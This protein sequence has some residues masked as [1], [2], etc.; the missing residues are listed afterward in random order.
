VSSFWFGVLGGVAAEFLGL[1]DLRRRAPGEW[2]EYLRLPTYW[3]LSA[4]MALL[5]GALVAVY[6]ASDV[7]VSP[8]IGINIGASAPLILQTFARAAPDIPPG[9]VD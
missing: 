2:P 9:T 3:I 1:Y 5:G 4:V 7:D 6:V 8:I